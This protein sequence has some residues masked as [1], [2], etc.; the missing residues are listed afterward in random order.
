MIKNKMFFSHKR[1]GLVIAQLMQ[2]IASLNFW[3][4][5]ISRVSSIYWSGAGVADVMQRL[6][7]IQAMLSKLATV[8]EY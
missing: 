8:T 3:H 6:W 5:T 2:C 1:V 4:R 7:L